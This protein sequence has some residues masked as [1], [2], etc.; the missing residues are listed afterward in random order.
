MSNITKHDEVAGN[1]KSILHW[2][3]VTNVMHYF[4]L[5]HIVHSQ[6]RDWLYLVLETELQA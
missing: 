4:F 2:E 5:R 6:P 3:I 1:I